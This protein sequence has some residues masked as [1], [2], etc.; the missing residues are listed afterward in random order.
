MNM[1]CGGVK[2]GVYGSFCQWC[3]FTYPVLNI[4]PALD[5]SFTWLTCMWG[6]KTIRDRFQY[7]GMHTIY[8]VVCICVLPFR[9]LIPEVGLAYL[10]DNLLFV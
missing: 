1:L 8:T 4:N 5:N 9:T 3:G 2:G 7:V 10:P 6:G